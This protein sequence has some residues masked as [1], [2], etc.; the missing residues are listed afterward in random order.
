M[1]EVVKKEIEERKNSGVE[2]TNEDGTKVCFDILFNISLV[3]EFLRRVR[4]LELI[5]VNYVYQLV[6]VK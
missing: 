1:P 6:M 4:Q 2:E 5:T 3:F